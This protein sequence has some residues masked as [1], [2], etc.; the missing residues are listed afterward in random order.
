MPEY[1][2]IEI[3]EP[4]DWNIA[5]SIM[6]R[7]LQSNLN[8]DFSKIKIFLSDV[9]GVMTDAGMYYTENGDE[10]KKFCTYDGMGMKLVV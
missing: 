8:L 9:D 3:D 2:F 4:E 7:N 6:K 5:E 1:T 10:F